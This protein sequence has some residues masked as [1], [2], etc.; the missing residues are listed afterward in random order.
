MK[1]QA[2][3]ME[4]TVIRTGFFSLD[5][6]RENLIGVLEFNKDNR[7]C[8]TCPVIINKKVL[9]SFNKSLV[10]RIVGAIFAPFGARKRRQS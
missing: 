1:V 9:G 6:E 4:W 5:L 2:W 7:K 10:S 8:W 3:D